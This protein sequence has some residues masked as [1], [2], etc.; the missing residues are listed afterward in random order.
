M[1]RGAW[2]ATVQRVAKNWTGLS[3]YAYTHLIILNNLSFYRIVVHIII[4][5]NFIFK[6][7]IE[8]VTILLLF[9]VW[10]FGHEARG[11]LA[12]K[13]GSNPHPRTG[14][15]TQLQNLNHWTARDVPSIIIKREII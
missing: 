11:I 10:F 9:H 15:Q 8:F 7:F 1:D 14:R 3:N 12:A 4:V 13:Q 5:N 6:V 2:W